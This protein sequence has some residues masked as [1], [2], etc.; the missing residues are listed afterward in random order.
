MQHVHAQGFVTN[1]TLLLPILKAFARYTLLEML[2]VISLRAAVE[3]SVAPTNSPLV[4]P[5][6]NI[7]RTAPDAHPSRIISS[8]AIYICSTR[9]YLSSLLLTAYSYSLRRPHDPTDPLPESSQATC[10]LPYFS[11]ITMVMAS[12]PKTCDSS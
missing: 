11:F 10:F 7:S 8:S 9:A 3:L 5:I 12:N 1:D 4:L 6:V 2:D